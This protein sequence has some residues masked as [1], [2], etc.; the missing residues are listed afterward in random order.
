MTPF[1][2]VVSQIRGTG[3]LTTGLPLLFGF[4]GDPL[5]SLVGLDYIPFTYESPEGRSEFGFDWMG[6]TN[7][8]Y[9]IN[10]ANLLAFA[11]GDPTFSPVS[12]MQDASVPAEN[13]EAIVDFWLQRL[14]QNYY[15]LEERELVI[16]FLGTDEFGAPSALDQTSPEYDVRIRN[17]VGFILSAPQAQKQ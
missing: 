12:I 8:L 13:V 1:E 4:G 3:A 14:Y 2:F 5:A 16:Q 11:D 6:S 17:L 7:L 10:F 15:T 9:R